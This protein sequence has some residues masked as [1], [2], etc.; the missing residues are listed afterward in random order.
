RG[1][2]VVGRGAAAA[3]RPGS[4]FVVRV[5][6]GRGRRPRRV[7]GVGARA[8]SGAGLVREARHRSGDGRHRVLAALPAARLSRGRAQ[9]LREKIAPMY[10]SALVR[11][12]F[13]SMATETAPA[14][15]VGASP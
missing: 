14:V 4:V 13:E 6:R 11:V 15:S 8:A 9:G 3:G 5:D 10:D 2:R 12:S 7:P 1:G